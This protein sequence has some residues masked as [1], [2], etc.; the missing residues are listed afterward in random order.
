M[1]IDCGAVHGEKVKPA[2]W[3]W[4]LKIWREHELQYVLD[5]HLRFNVRELW[6]L[7]WNGQQEDISFFVSSLGIVWS[8]KSISYRVFAI[9]SS[10]PWLVTSSIARDLKFRSLVWNLLWIFCSFF[11]V[12]WF[13]FWILKNW[14]SRRPCSF[15]WVFSLGHFWVFIPKKLLP[16]YDRALQLDIFTLVLIPDFVHLVNEEHD[17]GIS[18]HHMLFN[19]SI[20]AFLFVGVKQ[21]QDLF[22]AEDL[23]LLMENFKIVPVQRLVDFLQLPNVG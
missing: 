13:V 9:N 17:N 22:S 18:S 4:M 15:D 14:Y 3:V 11:G 5:A 10:Q 2:S 23:P 6:R 16:S 12:F 21:V 8:P 19:I 1:V 7:L 20:K